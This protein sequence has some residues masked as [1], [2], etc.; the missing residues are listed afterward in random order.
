MHT[1]GSRPSLSIH[2]WSVVQALQACATQTGFDGVEQSLLALH[3]THG[4]ALQAGSV[5]L[6]FAHWPLVAQGTQTCPSPQMG[7]GPAQS[8]SVAQPTQAPPRQI[9]D[10]G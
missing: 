1:P 9:R 7:F 8:A 10:V 4:P 2:C 6:L 3:S 5:L